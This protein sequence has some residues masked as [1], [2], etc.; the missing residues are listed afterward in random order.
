MSHEI[1]SMAY[2]NEVPWHGLGH[3]V[4]DAVGVDEM[5]KLAKLDWEVHKRPM[6]YARGINSDGDEY[7]CDFSGNV[8]RHFS[9]TRDSDGACLDVVGTAYKPTQNREA[10][11]FFSE[12]VEA[13]DAFMETAGSL[14]GGRT[15]WGLANL[16]DG[17]TLPGKDEVRGYLLV[18]SP[19]EAGKSLIAKVTTVRVVCNN[20]LTLALRG[21]GNVFR[22]AHRRRFD[23][24]AIDEAKRTLG[25]ARDQLHEFEETAVTLKGIPMTERETIQ[26]LAQ[27][28]APEKDLG[29]LLD[30]FVGS[31]PPKLARIMDINKSAPGADPDT[32]W[33]VLNAVTYFCDHVASRGVDKRIQNAWFGKT[34]KQKEDVLE[35]LLERAA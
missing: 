19:H 26:V 32:A 21:G 15:V 11:E 31:A 34:A 9:L 35:L 25:I 7:N 27:V 12:F 5:I 6:K 28:Y 10:F 22:F 8:P 33:G 14:R 20:T 18:A 2:T 24:A 1:E 30:D 17:F 16:R 29:A 4:G 23:D 3:Y 13:G